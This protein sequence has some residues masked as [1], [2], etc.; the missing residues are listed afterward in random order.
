MGDYS[1]FMPSVN[2]SGEVNV[3][4]EVYVGTGAKIINQINIG[5]QT[6]IGAGA[7]VAK[8]LPARCML[9]VYPQNQ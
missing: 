7:V 6:I 5:E 8:D 3:G 9:S 4:K 1:A 2:I